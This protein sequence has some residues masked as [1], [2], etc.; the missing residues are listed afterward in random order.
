MR[1]EDGND[2][3][4]GEHAAAERRAEAKQKRTWVTPQVRVVGDLRDLVLGQ[5]KLVQRRFG[6]DRGS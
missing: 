4:A 3:D 5:G 2:P 1:T 6:S